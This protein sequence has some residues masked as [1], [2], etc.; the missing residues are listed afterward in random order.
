MKAIDPN[1]KRYRELL[2]LK[3]R[4]LDKMRKHRK[5]LAKTRVDKKNINEEITQPMSHHPDSTDI[6]EQPADDLQVDED[7]YPYFAGDKD[8]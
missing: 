5:A 3:R 4:L 7:G 1:Q 6:D 2:K 8:E